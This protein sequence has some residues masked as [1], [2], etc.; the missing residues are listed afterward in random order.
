[1]P[2]PGGGH[3][4]RRRQDKRAEGGERYHEGVAEDAEVLS[5]VY[6]VI[7]DVAGVD[8]TWDVVEVHLLGLNAVMDSIV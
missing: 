7:E 6:F 4:D 8:D 1:M 2:N 3:P 5:V